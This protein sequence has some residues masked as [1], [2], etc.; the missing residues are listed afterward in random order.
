MSRY[1][2]LVF[3]LSFIM[4]V[5]T[6]CKEDPG[7]NAPI[8]G[9]WAGTTADFK[10]NPTGIIPAFSL[11]EQALPVKLQF[12]NDGKVVLTDEKGLNES[13]TYTL[14]GDK[15]TLNIDYAFELIELSGT[16]TIKE[17]TASNL[18]AETERAGSYTH[19]DTGQQ[20]TGTVIA[21]LNF[22]KTN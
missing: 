12:S 5:I 2:K 21:R 14:A 22:Q 10:I 20:F 6:G 18:S 13:G 8:V 3:F 4:I 1:Y 17:L 7:I 9:K 19:P 16:Y 11:E 15:L